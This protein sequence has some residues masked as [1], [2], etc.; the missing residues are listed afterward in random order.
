[1]KEAMKPRPA[2]VYDDELPDIIN[3]GA[4]PIPFGDPPGTKGHDQY[5]TIVVKLQTRNT[6]GG[7]SKYAAPMS[8]ARLDSEEMT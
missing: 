5:L 6:I 7:D 4:T 8:N 2:F 3:T 1:M